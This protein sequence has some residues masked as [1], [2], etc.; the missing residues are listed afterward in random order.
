MQDVLA[1]LNIQIP[2]KERVS[3]I[4]NLMKNKDKNF[5]ELNLTVISSTLKY[6]QNTYVINPF[7]LK[8]SKRKAKDGIVLFGYEKKN[9][10][11]KNENINT[12]NNIYSND[13]STNNLK[14]NLIYN[15]S[16]FTNT[17]YL[18]DFVFP[19]EEKNE[20]NSLY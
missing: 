13:N 6:E 10:K 17:F 16:D 15:E 9:I 7:G 20:N 5:N 3:E 2:Y 19:I 14:N 1:L 4:N 8:N 18:N 12:D 11:K